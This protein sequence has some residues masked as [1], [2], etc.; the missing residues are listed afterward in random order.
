MEFGSNLVFAPTDSSQEYEHIPE[1]KFNHVVTGYASGASVSTAASS[2]PDD[3]EVGSIPHSI[4]EL[5]T[6]T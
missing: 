4:V 5:Y 1:T 3:G 6:C 2:L